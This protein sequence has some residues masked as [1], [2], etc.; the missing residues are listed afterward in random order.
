MQ[1][2]LSCN[3]LV[4]RIF[5]PRKPLS[6]MVIILRMI[7]MF[8]IMMRNSLNGQDSRHKLCNHSKKSV[9]VGLVFSS[10][11]KN[12][13]KKWRQML[14]TNIFGCDNGFMGRSIGD[15]FSNFVL[16]FLFLLRMTSISWCIRVLKIGK[17]K[18]K[19]VKID[20]SFYALSVIVNVNSLERK[21]CR[22][23]KI[24]HTHTWH[25]TVG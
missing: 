18:K 15:Y 9:K 10:L 4:K 2:C 3:N 6:N 20:S 24:T 13:Y 21:I 25:G 5:F 23:K 16:V 11:W 19:S 22:C 1:S 17:K 14:K 8:I 12:G 7:M